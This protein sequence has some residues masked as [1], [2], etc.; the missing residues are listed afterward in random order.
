MYETN[1]LS[2]LIS[3][4][5]RY[6]REMCMAWIYLAILYKILVCFAYMMGNFQRFWCLVVQS[7]DKYR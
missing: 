7:I 1:C 5:Y 3:V 4:R 2:P 6:T